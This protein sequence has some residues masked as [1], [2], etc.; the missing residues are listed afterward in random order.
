VDG[1]IVLLALVVVLAVGIAADFGP[2][3]PHADAAAE[4][5]ADAVLVE[6]DCAQQRRFRFRGEYAGGVPALQL[7]G[8]AEFTRDVREARLEVDVQ[9][10]ANGR[11]YAVRVAGADE[12]ARLERRDGELTRLETG[13]RARPPVDACR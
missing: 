3:R 2:K 9:A 4:R 1:R 7:W 13:D 6:V 5:T 10:S 11:A 8:V 12:L